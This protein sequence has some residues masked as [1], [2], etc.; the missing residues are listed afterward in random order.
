MI[1]WIAAAVIVYC[2]CVP[3][4]RTRRWTCKVVPAWSQSLFV[5]TILTVLAFA[6][7]PLGWFVDCVIDRCTGNWRRRLLEL[8][9]LFWTAT[10]LALVFLGIDKYP[11]LIFVP[12]LVLFDSLYVIIS[13]LVTSSSTPSPP[14]P[15]RALMLDLVRYLQ[16]IGAFACLYLFV[17]HLTDS[18]LFLINNLPGRLTPEESLYFSIA[19]GTTIGFGDITPYVAGRNSLP[20]LAR[21]SVLVFLEVFCIFYIFAI[22]MPRVIGQIATKSKE[23][24]DGS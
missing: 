24:R 18:S 5:G 11:W 20:M 19:S 1:W 13:L 15:A 22:D 4:F 3:S 10:T 14:S 21:P 2:L 16:V 12:L 17:Q 23:S 7:Y 6:S 9:V 8:W